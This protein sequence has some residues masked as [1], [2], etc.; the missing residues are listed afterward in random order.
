ML[1]TVLVD[2]GGTLWPNHPRR[3][4][5]AEALR[6]AQVRTAL[7]P[8][9]RGREAEVVDALEAAMDAPRGAAPDG[10]AVPV[11]VD[12]LA[13]GAVAGLGVHVGRLV[14]RRI[15]RAMTLPVAGRFDLLPGAG[16][17][18]AAIRQL[19]LPCVLVSNTRWRDATHYLAD[20][21]DLG[22]GGLVDGV[23]TSLDVGVGKPHPAM[24]EAALALARC[25]AAACV[26]IGNS[27]T[28]DVEPAARLGMR[29]MLVWPD[30]PAP[31]DGRG[32]ATWAAP[33]LRE[34]ARVLRQATSDQQAGRRGGGGDALSYS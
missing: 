30:D 27:L 17:L 28:K 1:E 23:V 18:L 3:L 34:A 10:G 13:A 6:L 7:P 16:D 15:R 33:D 31:A 29:T 9:L 19:G 24:F 12:T 32:G 26:M 2:V 22:V 20:F 25:P 21:A 4:P 5:G 11:D 8:A 14:A